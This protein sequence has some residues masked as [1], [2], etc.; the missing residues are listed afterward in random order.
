VVPLSDFGTVGVTNDV[1]SGGGVAGRLGS[2]TWRV[3]PVA[4]ITSSGSSR[5]VASSNP[6]GAVPGPTT[7]GGRSFTV[8]FRASL[9]G[10]VPAHPLPGAPLPAWFR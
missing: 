10:S 2:P 1:A 5:Y 6:Y 4:L 3:T 9:G 7:T 8:A